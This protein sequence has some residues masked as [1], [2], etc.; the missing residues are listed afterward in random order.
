M[1]RWKARAEF[2]LSVIELLFLSL[3]VEALQGKMCQNSL[4][5]GVD[6]SLGAK[7]SGGRGRPSGIFFGFYK[8]RRILLSE[9]PN[10][11]V[12]RAVVLTQYRR[13]TDGQ[14]DT[15]TDRRTELL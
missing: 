6:R 14:T 4:P 12:L 15:R 7:I 11:T 8:T 1:A 13:V 5:S 10:C 3:T 9:I 2:L